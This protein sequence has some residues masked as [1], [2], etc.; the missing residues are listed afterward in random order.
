[1]II[2]RF[3]MLPEQERLPVPVS[4]YAFFSN[5]SSASFPGKSFMT[6]L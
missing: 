1:M 2:T 4:S 3:Y 5:T 6:F